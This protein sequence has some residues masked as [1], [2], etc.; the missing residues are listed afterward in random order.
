M[1]V[2]EK[3]KHIEQQIESAVADVKSSKSLQEIKM[4]FLGKT[5]E[6]SSLMK[7][8]RD[9]PPEQRPSLGKLLNALRQWTEEKLDNLESGIK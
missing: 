6:I 3:I 8:M 7:N 9:V 4:R 5:G 1:D 2:N